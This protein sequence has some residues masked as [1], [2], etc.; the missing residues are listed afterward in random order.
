MNQPLL[1]EYGKQI[2]TELKLDNKRKIFY[3][4][5]ID[6]NSDDSIK[7][8]IQTTLNII[9]QD[10]EIMHKTIPDNGLGWHVDN[11]QLVITKNTLQHDKDKYIKIKENKYLYYKNRLPSITIIFYL[12]T[13]KKDFDG[14]LLRFCDDVEIK[15][16]LGLGIKFDSREVHMVTPIKN[17]IRKVILCK[18]YS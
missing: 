15:P 12:S 16:Q 4:D 13:Y 6:I 14:G 18:I 3:F 11:C 2:L 9:S 10:I 5:Q 1:Y 8:F 17:G 7:Y